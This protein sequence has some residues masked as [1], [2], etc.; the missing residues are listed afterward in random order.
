M[1]EEKEPLTIVAKIFI[2]ILLTG[3]I[4]FVGISITMVVMSI[5]G[6]NIDILFIPWIISMCMWF[7]CAIYLFWCFSKHPMGF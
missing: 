2:T 6:T 5:V 3:V 7:P 4:S 1:S